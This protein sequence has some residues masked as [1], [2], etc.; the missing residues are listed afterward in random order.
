M[1][2]LLSLLLAVCLLL[3][4]AAHGHDIKAA[5]IRAHI[6]VLASDVFEGRKPGTIGETKT[7]DYITD[8]WNKAGLTPAANDGS[9]K[10]AV[11]LVQRAP[12]SSK[13]SFTQHGQSLKFV[14]DHILMMGR[15]TQYIKSDLPLFF[16]GSG[17]GSDGNAISGVAG[18]AVIILLEKPENAPEDKASLRARLAALWNAHAEAVLIVADDPVN[19]AA[20]R[21]RYLS[22]PMEL[23]EGDKH[24]P[25][26]AILSSDYA[27]A[28]LSA[29]GYDWDKLRNSAKNK[30]YAGENLS[31]KANFD[32]TT[33][34]RR[35]D[36]YNLIGKIAAKTDNKIGGNGAVL[37]LAHWDHLGHCA[38]NAAGDD[39]CNGAVDNASGIAVLSEVAKTLA[40]DH[41]D[42]DIYFMA[43]TGEESGLLGA[44]SFVNNPPMPLSS[45]VAAFN[46]DTVAI[47]KKGSSVAIVGRG[48]TP[49]DDAIDK[50]AKSE[51]RKIES[52]TA[53]NAFIQRQDGW[54]LVQKGVPA[55]MAG[56]S[57]ADLPLLQDFL[58]H[59]YHGPDDELTDKTELGGA[60]EDAR[61]HVALGRF[62]A[63]NRYKP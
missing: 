57:F 35:F 12:V 49:L 8:I 25:L 15:E 22:R 47:A 5:D 4:S 45:I 16:A 44:F 60:T 38:A 51:H 13:F 2:R 20:M 62:F 40:S 43:T 30:D 24:A 14:G 1:G 59:D 34:I 9:W 28:L 54:A 56:G 46:L 50:I 61:L 63:S 36:S 55:V 33:E 17:V 7:I 41:Y 39:I 27:V 52:S 29:A 42:R 31:I 32:V 37:F 53:A 10:Q 3:S 48:K 23:Q 18:K 6:A 11:P 58:G 21:R 26:E 19:Y